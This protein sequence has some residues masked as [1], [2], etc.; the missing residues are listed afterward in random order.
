[1]ET[2]LGNEA[3]RDIP[4]M[5]RRLLWLYYIGRTRQ[6]LMIIICDSPAIRYLTPQIGYSTSYQQQA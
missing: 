3:H 5:H 6:Q 1:L 2:V 4:L